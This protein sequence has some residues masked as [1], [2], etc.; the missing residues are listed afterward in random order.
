MIWDLTETNHD[1]CYK[2]SFIGLLHPRQ[3]PKGQNI[4]GEAS[5]KGSHH[6]NLTQLVHC[7][8]M[9]QAGAARVSMREVSGMHGAQILPGLKYGTQRVD[10]LVMA[11]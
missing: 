6:Y 4:D 11:S 5:K 2:V 1:P 10:S 3:A 9:S 8:F 7:L